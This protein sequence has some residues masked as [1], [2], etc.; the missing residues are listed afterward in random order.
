MKNKGQTNSEELKIQGLLDRY[1]KFR[2]LTVT[3]DAHLNE[4]S[5]NAFVEGRLSQRESSPLIKHLIDCSFCLNVT[6][7]LVKLELDF[8]D[9]FQTISVAASEPAKVS[10]VLKGL[11]SRIFGPQDDAV[12]AHQETKETP[13]D[14]KETDDKKEV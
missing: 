6:A 4:D 1:L 10:D 3:S 2:S 11:L 5:L 14:Q 8:A 9:E 12:F 7:E 13:E